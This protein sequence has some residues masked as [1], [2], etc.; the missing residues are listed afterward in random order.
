MITLHSTT[1]IG[2]HWALSS[3]CLAILSSVLFS[4][5]RCAL[6]VQECW[7][8]SQRPGAAAM[9]HFARLCDFLHGGRLRL[10]ELSH[11]LPSHTLK[12]PNNANWSVSNGTGLFF[13]ARR[14]TSRSPRIRRVLQLDHCRLSDRRAAGR[15]GA[16]VESAL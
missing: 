3:C 2:L 10:D 13:A 6:I 9:E 11:R 4:R 1:K 12:S 8:R 16:G 5:P 15:R 14:I 7:P